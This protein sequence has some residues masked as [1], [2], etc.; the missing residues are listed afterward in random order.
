M[1][2]RLNMAHAAALAVMLSG[3]YLEHGSTPGGDAG[4]PPPPP[5]RPDAS[6]VTPPAPGCGGTDRIA[7]AIESVA[8]YP[9]APGRYEESALYA[10]EAVAGGLRLRFDMCPTADAECRCDGPV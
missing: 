6:M 7:V 4:V 3:C 5:V 10:I 2:A 1:R 8:G 9:C